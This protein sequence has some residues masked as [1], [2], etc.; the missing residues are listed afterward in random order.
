MSRV[1]AGVG[2][3]SG[4]GIGGLI[5]SAIGRN[6]PTQSY[7]PMEATRV[8]AV[9]GAVLGSFTGAALGAGSEKPKQIAIVETRKIDERA[10]P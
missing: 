9:F 4:I 10:F 8:G 3:I 1:M 7:T 2:A 6:V 5:G